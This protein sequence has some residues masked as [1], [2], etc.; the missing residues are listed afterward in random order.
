MFTSH[1]NFAS[2]KVVYEADFAPDFRVLLS[3]V[4]E[5]FFFEDQLNQS[6]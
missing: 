3:S 6:S 2:V 1:Y 4:E 5:D